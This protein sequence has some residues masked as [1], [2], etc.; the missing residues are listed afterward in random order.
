MSLRIRA[1]G[2]IVCA[3]MHPEHPGDVYID[4]ETHYRIGVVCRALEALPA[5]RWRFIAQGTRD[6]LAN[7]SAHME[8]VNN[9]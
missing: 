3:A 7:E 5:G 1:N 6:M 2:E 4:D 8:G 9:V